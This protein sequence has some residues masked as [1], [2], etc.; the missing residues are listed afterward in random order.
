MIEGYINSGKFFLQRHIGSA[1]SNEISLKKGK[2][3][4]K[5]ENDD[6]PAPVVIFTGLYGRHV[7]H[8]NG[9]TSTVLEVQMLNIIQHHAG[10]DARKDFGDLSA[11][12]VLTSSDTMGELLPRV[13]MHTYIF[14]CMVFRSCTFSFMHIQYRTLHI[15]SNILSISLCMYGLVFCFLIV[16]SAMYAL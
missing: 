1:R 12:N 3:T 4:L 14:T 10:E 6:L 5:S 13:L 2:W 15:I 7:F 9:C 8:E 16:F 11:E